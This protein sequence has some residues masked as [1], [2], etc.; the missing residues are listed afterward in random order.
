MTDVF[1]K[2]DPISGTERELGSRHRDGGETRT[3]LMRRRYDAEVED[4]WDACT[5]PDRLSRFFMK[6]SGDL[7]QGGTFSFEGNAGGRILRCEPPRRLTVTWVYGEAGDLP[8]DQVELRLSPSGDGTELELEHSSFGKITGL[9][10]NDPEK[11][12]W[13]LGAGWEL[14]LI[15][16]GTYLRGEFPDVAP[17]EI[18]NM[19]EITDLADRISLAWAAVL[20]KAAPGSAA[21]T[22]SDSAASTTSDEDPA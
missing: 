14:G 22:A 5:D 16:L 15:A 9:L 20:D 19:P 4:V 13:G 2:D 6:P 18:G 12:L 1:G 3:I 8:E 21:S 17:A 10:L 11:G 7:R